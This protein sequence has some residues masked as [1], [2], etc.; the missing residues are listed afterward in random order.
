M[1]STLKRF[2]RRLVRFRLATLFFV[3][4][5]LAVMLGMW[6]VPSRRQAEAVTALRAL[7]VQ[8]FYTYHSSDTG[9]RP[10]AE[11]PCPTWIRKLL[12]DDFLYRVV[13]VNVRS[14]SSGWG[15]V[16]R[17]G[18]LEDIQYA[19]VA[20][21]PH[22]RYL[23]V[24]G[25]QVGD[26]ALAHIGRAKSLERIQLDAV[27]G[28]EPNVPFRKI[29]GGI[30]DRGLEHL[31]NL[32]RLESLVISTNYRG[33]P[34]QS[35]I[36]D[37]GLAPIA[38][39]EKLFELYLVRTSIRGPGLRHLRELPNLEI[40]SIDT[41]PL[42]DD[43]LEHLA[44]CKKLRCIELRSVNVSPTGFRRLAESESLA[45]LSLANTQIG[46]HGLAELAY[47]PGLEY[48]ELREPIITDVGIAALAGC[49]KLKQLRLWEANI[50]DGALAQLA[51]LKSLES[52]I[53]KGDRL[54]DD[55]VRKLIRELPNCKV[56]YQFKNPQP[57]TTS[58]AQSP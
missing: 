43:G 12:G 33:R 20:N 47:L 38:R 48:L 26:A 50:T 28:S 21:L 54:T 29:E 44:A 56:Q 18:H 52:L 57:A 51:K 8:V 19:Y 10:D 42:R 32:S 2:G 13:E 34:G 37:D 4:T 7:R 14:I 15:S 36:T 49:H 55:G 41:A 58:A 23:N 53:I 17:H 3:M 24:E 27:D 45:H 11:P 25:P 5:M 30:S 1:I 35:T 16:V 46:D 39:L 9:W 6:A 31:A 40:L 22:L